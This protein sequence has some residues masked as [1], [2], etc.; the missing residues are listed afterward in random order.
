MLPSLL[1]RSL[2]Q[3]IARKVARRW[4]RC[5]HNNK[6][7][8]SVSIPRAFF[9]TTAS[10]NDVDDPFEQ[11]KE[12][13]GGVALGA[14]DQCS[15]YHEEEEE[16]ALLLKDLR[17]DLSKAMEEII[18]LVEEEEEKVE[19][20]QRPSDDDQAQDDDDKAENDNILDQRR[21]NGL[22]ERFAKAWRKHEM[23]KRHTMG[24][25]NNITP[26]M[27]WKTFLGNHHEFG[28][29]KEQSFP[30][31]EN[32]LVNSLD[33]L[34]LS[35]SAGAQHL[36]PSND[37][38]I[39]SFPGNEMTFAE[40][41]IPEQ[42]SS[43]QKALADLPFPKFSLD[44]TAA[45]EQNKVALTDDDD[46]GNVEVDESMRRETASFH[47]Q[48]HGLEDQ[49]QPSM[50]I[51]SQSELE[52]LCVFLESM[53]PSDWA[54]VDTQDY[55]H[56]HFD[57]DDNHFD[58]DDHNHEDMDIFD[59]GKSQDED[60]IED[61]IER[62]LNLALNTTDGLSTEE[63]N[64]I[65][66]RISTA[67][68][69]VLDSILESLLQVY[70]VMKKNAVPDETTYK[71][72]LLTLQRRMAGNG[73]MVSLLLQD[74]M[75]FK[76]TLSSDALLVMGMTCLDHENNL[77]VAKRFLLDYAL[78]AG[79]R[80]RRLP[81]SC[82][83]TLM[84]MM[85]R[86]DS[87]DDAISLLKLCM[88]V[89]GLRH[90]RD[91]DSVVDVAF[92]WPDRNRAGQKRDIVHVLRAF[93]EVILD[94]KNRFRYEPS[95]KSW[96]NIIV[97]LS[98]TTRA[99]PTR[100]EL[101]RR[102]FHALFQQNQSFYPGETLLRIGLDYCD[103]TGDSKLARDLIVR[104]VDH[105][106]RSNQT[107]PASPWGYS[108]SHEI[109]NQD[110]LEQE[111]LES[112]NNPPVYN[113]EESSTP[114][115]TQNVQFAGDV[116]HSEYTDTN[117]HGSFETSWF[118]TQNE[119][120][121][122]EL[123]TVDETMTPEATATIDSDVPCH[124]SGTAQQVAPPLP[125]KAFT[126]SLRVCITAGDVTNA[127]SILE[128]FG[129]LPSVYPKDIESEVW[130]SALRGFSSLALDSSLVNEIFVQM[131][132]KG[133]KIDE[134]AYAAVLHC[135]AVGNQPEEA[136]KL[137]QE[138]KLGMFHDEVQPGLSCYNSM[139]LACVKAKD[140]GKVMEL[141]EELKA[142]ETAT[143]DATTQG[144]VIAARRMGGKEKARLVLQEA[145]SAST[146]VSRNN[147]HVA[148]KILMPDLL[149]GRAFRGSADVAHVQ[150]MLRELGL[151]NEMLRPA[152]LDLMRSCRQ[153][154]IEQRRTP[155]K[156]VSASDLASRRNAAWKEALEDILQ[157]DEVRRGLKD[158][159]V[160]E[161]DRPGK[162]V[163]FPAA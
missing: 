113:N 160:V 8:V 28:G 44:S 143:N 156:H 116:F 86:E 129:R 58:D 128:A 135:Y 112:L 142:S 10:A 114:L 19:A 146:V 47:P 49:L 39:L 20:E 24:I 53:R 4:W 13:S 82:T 111:T 151:E 110:S 115:Q 147:C 45:G 63:Y 150:E 89:N 51:Q 138:M 136:M 9:A 91:T 149:S 5:N 48:I 52:K 105:H 59:T 130:G 85:S 33:D 7:V 21:E 36:H 132:Q 18:L 126:K 93:L 80:N 163:S 108:N 69:L 99:D 64:L 11:T 79:R 154:D 84:K 152:C 139:I 72:L 40:L 94:K 107:M 68:N 2:R 42:Q 133:L 26:G 22:R 81:Q 6:R 157:L 121:T 97:A 50:A 67:P 73:I 27:G 118:T 37:N 12:Q 92:Q 155:T 71:I 161:S 16:A 103:A 102:P 123:D 57:D 78:D 88:E 32:L 153:A 158:G 106:V 34:K 60:V 140:Y 127:R 144:V 100:W 77:R 162:E 104:S 76:V 124:D 83:R 137:F 117:L 96:Q 125:F 55:H 29:D 61:D 65:L 43:A 145:L 35:S 17:G 120:G 66:A 75:D 25:A 141:Y 62:L 38:D 95:F 1:R 159:P 122:M 148:L 23:K 109:S 56:E 101:L 41:K 54:V 3:D 70:H 14:T 74:M 31:E 98:R 134:E 87:V 131:K 15:Q 30:E 90:S 46:D 119:F